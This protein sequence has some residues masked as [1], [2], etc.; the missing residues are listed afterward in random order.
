MADG[1][2][3]GGSQGDGQDRPGE[4]GLWGAVAI[5]VG[6]MVGGG[7]FAVLG[8]AATLAGGGVPVAFLAGGLLALLTAYC[9]TRL[10]VAF[11]SAGGSVVFVNT[12]FGVDYFTG[13]VNNLL[14]IGYIVTLALYAYAFGHYAVTLLPGAWHS[15]L[16]VHLLISLAVVL[17][18]LLNLAAASVISRAETY[19]VG[20][21]VAI[22]LLVAVSG[23]FYVDPA[24][25]SPAVWKPLPTIIGSGM[26]IFV[27][28][29]GFELI[30]NAAGGVRDAARTLPRA[31][32]TAVG[33]VTLLY[34]LIA[35]VTVGCLSPQTIAQAEDYALAAAARPALGAF[36]YRIV[37]VSA[38]LATLSA[39]N[40]T[41][42]GAARLS[43]VIATSGELPEFLEDRVWNKPVVGLLI[44][45]G[46]SLLLAN[47]GGL[48]SISTMAS[49]GFLIIFATVN[50]AAF[51]LARR[52]GASRPL[53]AAGCLGC[54]AAFAVLLDHVAGTNP[55]HLWVLAGMAGLAM[56]V[57]GAYVLYLRKPEHKGKG[58]LH[59][60][61]GQTGG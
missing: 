46:L 4:V 14:L 19:I 52:V 39:I 51:V 11:P 45:A 60:P 58:R 37:A 24:R 53:A 35:V 7:I 16:T 17:P 29:E 28:Y 41:L 3:R 15:P 36:G 27:A 2:A 42:Y 13:V 9:Y 54:L 6:G 33:F 8:L 5:G 40:A 59:P 56:A 34:V 44:T 25:L 38:V 61:A 55:S 20:F 22:L 30:A 57:E 21:K 12:A 10:S 48:S 43:Y 26:V 31:Y 23:L 18:T 1:K 32:F 50:A 49:A 47:L